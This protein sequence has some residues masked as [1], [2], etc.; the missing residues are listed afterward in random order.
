MSYPQVSVCLAFYKGDKFITQQVI[1]ILLNSVHEVLI[2]NDDRNAPHPKALID[3]ERMDRRVKLL[4]GPSKGV[5]KNFEYMLSK[6]KGDII[7]LS[8]QDDVWYPNKV[9]IMN[10]CF[11]SNPSVD[12]VISDCQISNEAGDIIVESLLKLRRQHTKLARILIKGPL[13]CCMAI[14][15]TSLEYILPLPF[16]AD[17]FSMHDWWIA[18][19][20]ASLGKIKLLDEQLIAYRRHANTLT[21]LNPHISKQVD[22]ITIL[23]MI[24]WRIMI[25]A[26]IAKRVAKIQFLHCQTR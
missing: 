13:G 2:S 6:A 17:Q 8:D 16:F 12:L 22:I 1:S 3:L 4:W 14:R 9:K 24:Y 5:S 21:K 23:R 15:R 18:C 20:C 10:S 25:L 7:Y 11:I 26:S 19:M